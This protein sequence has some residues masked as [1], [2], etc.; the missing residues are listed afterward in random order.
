MQTVSFDLVN[1]LKRVKEN[2][3]QIPQF[4][5]PFVWREGQVKLLVDSVTRNYPIGSLLVLNRNSEM[6]L[7]SR[8]T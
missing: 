8:S 1:L 6:M 7:Q 5:R 3:Y 2:R 4:Q